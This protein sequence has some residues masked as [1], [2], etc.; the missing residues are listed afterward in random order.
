MAFGKTH[1]SFIMCHLASE[2][3][4]PFIF[5]LAKERKK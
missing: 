4:V 1:T 5:K 3:D 2:G